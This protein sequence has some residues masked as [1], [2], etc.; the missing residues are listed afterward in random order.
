[1]LLHSNGGK[2]VGGDGGTEGEV[3]VRG[4]LE[5]AHDAITA[6][7]LLYRLFEDEA[8]VWWV[9]NH[10]AFLEAMCMGNILRERVGEEGVDVEKDP[11]LARAKADV[12]ESR[13]C[14]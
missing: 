11:L 4:S 13:L 14:L 8:K 10:R 2:E 1:M 7:F 9:F 12:G 5:A 3:S 6:F